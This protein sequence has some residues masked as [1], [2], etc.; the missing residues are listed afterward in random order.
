M[1]AGRRGQW[2]HNLGA[3]AGVEEWGATHSVTQDMD[4]SSRARCVD[5]VTAANGGADSF[6]VLQARRLWGFRVYGFSVGV[7]GFWRFGFMHAGGPEP[8]RQEGLFA[9]PGGRTLNPGP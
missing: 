3:A 2:Q 9:C 1:C 5:A 8:C 6:R 4:T 7:L